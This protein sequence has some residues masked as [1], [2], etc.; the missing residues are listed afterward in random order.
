M[1]DVKEE[2]GDLPASGY[3]PDALAAFLATAPAGLQGWADEQLAQLNAARPAADAKTDTEVDASP[4]PA[5]EAV[6]LEAF[7]ED[8]EDAPAD[9]PKPAPKPKPRGPRPV[10]QPKTGVNKVNLILVTLLAAAVVII[11][12]QMGRP[13]P[14]AEP[15]GGQQLP[16]SHPDISSVPSG[17]LGAPAPEIDQARIDELKAQIEANPQDTDTRMALGELYLDSGLYQD[18]IDVL[19]PILDYDPDHLDAL[20]ALGVAEYNL[21][22]DA[23]A[24]A[25]WL[26]ATEVA[27]E[28]P[29][30]WYNLGFLY[31]S[32][33]PPEYDK[34]EA[35]WTK[36][37]ELAPGTE[38]AENA[39]AHLERMR[40]SSPTPS[41]GG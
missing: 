28:Q 31:M 41:T 34:A 3:D 40:Q 32:Q 30:P 23:A 6:G 36:V 7:T 16:S 21:E 19:A 15:T 24:E 38:L 25:H 13:A 2:P 29:A 20:L 39:Q 22:Q 9:A 27:P 8:F 17:G 26:R 4:E 18:A 37:I 35:A 5:D 10:A 33:T 1:G 11:I 14:V 12:Q